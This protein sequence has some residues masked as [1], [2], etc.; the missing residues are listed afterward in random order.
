MMNNGFVISIYFSQVKYNFRSPQFFI[1]YFIYIRE[2]FEINKILLN[3]VNINVFL[4]K[5]SLHRPFST[6]LFL[7]Q[8]LFV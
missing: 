3:K 6:L 2:K 7:L 5:M 8:K 4:L 1:L